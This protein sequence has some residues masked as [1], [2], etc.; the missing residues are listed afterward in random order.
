MN[1]I[2]YVI[3]LFLFGCT[4]SEP[5]PDP[6]TILA[7]KTWISYKYVLNH[8]TYDDFI[9]QDKFLSAFPNSVYQPGDCLKAYY[10]Y[11][12]TFYSDQTMDF[13]RI[14]K[15]YLKCADCSEYVPFDSSYTVTK[16]MYFAK[17]N[18]VILADSNGW[19]PVYYETLYINTDNIRFNKCVSVNNSFS[20]RERS[21]SGT[22]LERGK[23]YY[24]DIFMKTAQ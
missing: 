16:K 13:G 19:D 18:F 23:D 12:L 4:Q 22:R 1:K 5:A 2:F 17:D 10:T 6:A 24:V 15:R 8:N 7:S 11:K 3:L 21:F 14:R 9:L 20:S